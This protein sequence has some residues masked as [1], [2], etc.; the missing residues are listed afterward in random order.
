MHKSEKLKLA[1][2]LEARWMERWS[3]GPGPNLLQTFVKNNLTTGTWG[4]MTEQDLD[5]LILW[6]QSQLEP[7]EPYKTIYDILLGG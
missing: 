7:P 6:L 5:K 1:R 4:Q 3:P 2:T